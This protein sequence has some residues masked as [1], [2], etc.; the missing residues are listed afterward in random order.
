[1]PS[2]SGSCVHTH[3]KRTD[4]EVDC[5]FIAGDRSTRLS[6]SPAPATADIHQSPGQAA[7]LVAGHEDL[8]N[9][10]LEVNDGSKAARVW[11]GARVV[12]QID[13]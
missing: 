3:R 13:P 12:A 8:P 7:T 9:V 2:P 5:E 6:R 1:M 4:R 10:E 11:V